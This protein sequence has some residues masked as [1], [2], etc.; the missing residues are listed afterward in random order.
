[1]K[2]NNRLLGVAILFFVFAVAFSIVI[3]QTTSLAAV[4]GCFAL[5]FGSGMAAGAWIK[6]SRG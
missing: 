1:M 6:Q 5:G 2:S 3:W 4:I